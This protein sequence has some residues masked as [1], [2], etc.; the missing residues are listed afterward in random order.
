M[1]AD[2]PQGPYREALELANEAEFTQ[3]E[4]DAYQKV[5]DEIQ[6]VRELAEA[7]WAEGRAEGKAEGETAGQIRGILALLAARGIP[8]STEAR[9]HIDACKDG[10]TLDR[11][12]VLAATAASV[13]EVI[14]A[15]AKRV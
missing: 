4:H 10:A 2:L 6:Q 5:I 14:A 12:I 13:E 7:K 15:S 1:P 11:W 8:V 3:A 9:A